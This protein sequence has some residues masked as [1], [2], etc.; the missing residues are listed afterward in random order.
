MDPGPGLEGSEGKPFMGS[1]APRSGESS[2][3]GFQRGRVG[4]EH[5]GVP[6]WGVD[7]HVCWGR[8]SVTHSLKLC[9]SLRRMSTTYSQPRDRRKVRKSKPNQTHSHCRGAREKLTAAH[10]GSHPHF[11]SESPGDGSSKGLPARRGAAVLCR[12]FFPYLKGF[13]SWGEKVPS[14]SLPHHCL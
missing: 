8:G 5:P 6:G 2:W 4:A 7:G 1:G 13:S 14:L 9:R 10:S 3:K 11:S 12:Q